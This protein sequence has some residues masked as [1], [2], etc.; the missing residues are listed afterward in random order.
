MRSFSGLFAF[1]DLTDRREVNVETGVIAISYALLT[2]RKRDIAIALDDR[3]AHQG[4][5][6]MHESFANAAEA[7]EIAG[8]DRERQVLEQAGSGGTRQ[9][10]PETEEFAW[11][12]A[13]SVAPS[14][15]V[16]KGP[17][18]CAMNERWAL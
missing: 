8:S 11:I 9:A 15:R 1:I 2:M 13:V 17:E 12:A 6:P 10:T 14:R 18:F 16:E 4:H 7:P 3:N 5:T